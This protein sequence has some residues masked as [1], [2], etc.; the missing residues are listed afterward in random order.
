MQF[1][2]FAVMVSFCSLLGTLGNVPVLIVYSAKNERRTANTFIKTLAVIDLVVCAIIMPYSI[3]MEL[4][5]VTSDIVCRMFEFVRHVSIIASNLTLVAIAVERYV[6]VCLIGHRLTVYHLN[7]GIFVVFGVSVLVAIPSMGIFAA[8]TKEEV[9][10]VNCAFHHNFDD[11]FYFCHFTTSLLGP[12]LSRAYQAALMIL[13]F[14]T[15]IAI[16][17]FYA[18]VYSALWKRAKRRSLLQ[19]FK[20]D[21]EPSSV[22]LK[23][24]KT[25]IELSV[26]G[27]T[28]VGKEGVGGGGGGE[29]GKGEGQKKEPQP[30]DELM[31]Y[32]GN[33]AS[34]CSSDEQVSRL[35]AS[36]AD[37]Q[38]WAK[39][40][41]GSN[42]S[43]PTVM[44]TTIRRVTHGSRT[45]MHRRTARMLFLCSVVFLLTWLPFWVDVFNHTH[46]LF[47]R[48]LFFLGN[49]SNPLV[50]GIANPHFRRSFLKLLTGFMPRC[51]P[52]SRHSHHHSTAT[53]C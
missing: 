29:V 21:L 23:E 40:E 42:P 46:R 37:L 12:D 3:I 45:V 13:F 17:V 4:H 14:L 36:S 28:V 51:S 26:P 22:T 11:D 1:I 43:S 41:E 32:L 31:L 49:A 34:E 15:F 10:D 39:N 47:L 53:K 20:I 25:T 38:S 8:V 33:E 50:Y 6:A 5:L 16:V 35:A 30:S 2:A 7:Q 9:K 48:Y 24:K 19:S 44:T 27:S 52:C 18:I